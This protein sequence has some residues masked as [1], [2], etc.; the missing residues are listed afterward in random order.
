MVFAGSISNLCHRLCGC[1]HFGIVCLGI[2][3]DAKGLAIT[4]PLVVAWP[5]IILCFQKLFRVEHLP[6]DIIILSVHFISN[7]KNEQLHVKSPPSSASEELPYW[8]LELL[9]MILTDMSWGIIY[10]LEICS[11]VQSTLLYQLTQ[12]HFCHLQVSTQF[13]KLLFTSN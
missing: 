5:L 6:T 11:K 13:L 2:T 8:Q 1:I 4:H 10:D 9:Y 3:N 12:K 7:H